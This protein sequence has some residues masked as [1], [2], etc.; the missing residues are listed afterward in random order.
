M[1][2][3]LNHFM[4]KVYQETFSY[5]IRLIDTVIVLNNRGI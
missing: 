2:V 3:H 5:F 4:K 1:H